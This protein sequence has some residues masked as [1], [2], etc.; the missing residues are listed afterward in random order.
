MDTKLNRLTHIII[1]PTQMPVPIN[2]LRITLLFS[3][4]LLLHTHRSIA[5]DRKFQVLFIVLSSSNNV[6]TIVQVCMYSLYLNSCCCGYGYGCCVLFECL[7][8]GLL[9]STLPQ[10]SRNKP[11]SFCLRFLFFAIGAARVFLSQLKCLNFS[12]CRK[13]SGT[14]ISITCFIY[15]LIRPIKM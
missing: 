8:F 7:G 5:T 3:I 12:L 11:N 13:L 2:R 10:S 15:Y 14:I 9:F 6:A 1:L 4:P